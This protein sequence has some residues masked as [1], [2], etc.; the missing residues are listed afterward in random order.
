MHIN[1]VSII[2]TY[3]NNL[4]LSWLLYGAC[5]SPGPPLSVIPAQVRLILFALQQCFFK[6]GCL[7]TKEIK[8]RLIRRQNIMKFKNSFH[9]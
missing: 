1:Y 5:G 3:L 8:K 9:K 6:I 7:I 2:N 4:M